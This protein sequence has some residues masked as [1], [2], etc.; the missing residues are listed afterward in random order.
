MGVPVQRQPQLGALDQTLGARAPGGAGQLSAID[1]DDAVV[2]RTSQLQARCGAQQTVQLFHADGHARAASVEAQCPGR[3]RLGRGRPDRA[4][5]RAAR[6]GLNARQIGQVGAAAEV[7][8]A[9]QAAPARAGQGQP[10]ADL[11]Q[12]HGAVGH[13]RAFHLDA[14]RRAQQAADDARR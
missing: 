1:G 7:Q 14:R 4:A 10:L 5:E 12:Q 3:A 2:Q 9:V 11:L 6:A 13:A 8:A